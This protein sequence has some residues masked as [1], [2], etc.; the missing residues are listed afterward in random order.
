MVFLLRALSN[1]FEESS[2]NASDALFDYGNLLDDFLF[3]GKLKNPWFFLLSYGVLS[4]FL[5]NTNEL[6]EKQNTDLI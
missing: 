4:W 5:Q 1:R 6:G 3:R 2:P